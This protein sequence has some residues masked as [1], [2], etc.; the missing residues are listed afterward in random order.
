MRILAADTSTTTGSVALL[1][2]TRLLCEWTLLAVQT[3]NRRLLQTIDDCLAAV[4]WTVQEVDLFAVTTGP[5]SFTGLRIGLTTVKTLAWALGKP[6]VGIPSPDALAAPL[7]HAALPVCP[8]I[9]AHRKEVFWAPYLPDGRGGVHRTG[10]YAVSSIEN[11]IERTE[12]PT[13]FCG[14][15][16]LVYREALEQKLGA[17]A[18]G[19]PSV[20][21]CIRAGFIGQ[22]ALSRFE[23]GTH[24]DVMASAP[25]YVRPSEAELK[26]PGNVKRNRFPVHPP[27]AGLL[28]RSRDP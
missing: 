21:H 9:D 18:L 23:G 3:H 22:M 16:W 14:D 7:G 19:A 1:D 2:D 26:H 20:Y 25:L 4:G 17:W 8:L 27:F 5:G 11:V 15:G 10:V 28:R 6:L 24:E 13:L 12:G